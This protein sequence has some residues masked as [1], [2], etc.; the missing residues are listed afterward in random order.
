MFL[1]VR[2][3]EFLK[4]PKNY[5]TA[6]VKPRLQDD[7]DQ[8]DPKEKELAV[9]EWKQATRAKAYQVSSHINHR[10]ASH[11]MHLPRLFQE[12]FIRCEETWEEGIVP[13]RACLIDIFQTWRDLGLPGDR[14]FAFLDDEIQTA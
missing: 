9:Y 14:P 12:L 1:Q 10:D 8:L 7:F 11:A 4:P 5:P 13:L 6:F 3:S 2:W